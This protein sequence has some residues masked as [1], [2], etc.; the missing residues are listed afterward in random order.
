[1]R[2]GFA[3]Q[4]GCL[5]HQQRVKVYDARGLY[6]IIE[7]IIKK[8]QNKKTD[9]CCA[10]APRKLEGGCVPPHYIAKSTG[11]SV[12]AN[13]RRLA[14]NSRYGT[15]A[16]SRGE[17]YHPSNGRRYISTTTIDNLIP[18]VHQANLTRAANPTPMPCC[19]QAHTHTHTRWNPSTR[20]NIKI[21][22]ACTAGAHMDTRTTQFYSA[23]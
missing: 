7:N 11:M 1:M 16:A 5:S 22:G 12:P 10:V 15:V 9:T 19:A 3:N 18:V 6:D 4:S 21:G 17:D 23:R 13:A 2:V 8:K 14:G 20:E